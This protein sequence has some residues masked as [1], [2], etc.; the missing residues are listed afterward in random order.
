MKLM[1]FHL[2]PDTELPDDFKDKHPSVWIDIDPALFDPRRGHQMYNDFIDELEYAAEVGFDAIC[3]NEH[4]S[5]GYGMMPSPNLIASILARSSR[6]AALCI[7][8]NSVALYNPPT[9]VA[10]EMAMIDCISGGRMIAGFPVGSPQDTCYAYGQ[11]PSRCN[12][13]PRSRPAADPRSNRMRRISR[14]SSTMAMC[15][16][17][18]RTKWPRT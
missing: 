13:R 7:M 3:V 10:E 18:V 14:V 6:D 15:W 11:N 17:A 16:L 5:N 12:S 8:G 1:W 4:H 9:R 2:M